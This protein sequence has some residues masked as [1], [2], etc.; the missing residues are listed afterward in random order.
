MTANYNNAVRVVNRRL[1]DFS[2]LS[3]VWIARRPLQGSELIGLRERN[4]PLIS[5]FFALE[6]PRKQELPDPPAGKSQKLFSLGDGQEVCH[7][8]H[9]P[10]ITSLVQLSIRKEN[11]AENRPRWP[12]PATSGDFPFTGRSPIEALRR[13][14]RRLKAVDRRP[15]EEAGG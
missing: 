7:G 10:T 6:L 3:Q 8:N 5:A 9:A 2:R 11:P 12:R 4:N 1:A 13:P 15:K 14:L